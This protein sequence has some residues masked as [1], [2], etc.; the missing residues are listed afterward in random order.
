M[1]N[2]RPGQFAFFKIWREDALLRVQLERSAK[3][4]AIHHPLLAELEQCF[5]SIDPDVQAV[6]LSGSGEHFCAGMDLAE[7]VQRTA[8]QVMDN[9]RYWHRVFGLIQHCRVPVIAALHG[10]VIG[11]GLELA[12]ACHVRVAATNTFY[13]LPEAQRG[14]FVGGGASV[15]VARLIGA[16]RMVAMMLTG[17]TWGAQEGHAYGISHFLVEKEGLIDKATELG[18]LVALN[19]PLSN[20]LTMEAIPFISDM[21]REAGLF[22]EALTVALAQTG[23]GAAERAAF[24]ANRRDVSKPVVAS[25]DVS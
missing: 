12:V 10:A 1:S 6:I 8:T 20:R 14:I 5:L 25:E 19:A 18:R 3:R 21:P 7:N 24:F 4:N 17:A 22:A 9:S 23:T 15:R 11:G 16:D 13:Q 2:A